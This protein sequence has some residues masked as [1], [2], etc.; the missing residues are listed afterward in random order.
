M[1][2]KQYSQAASQTSHLDGQLQAFKTAKGTY[3][4]NLS[5]ERVQLIDGNA[6]IA[7]AALF[8]NPDVPSQVLRKL[9]IN[10]YI[11]I[12]DFGVD[13]SSSALHGVKPYIN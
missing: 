4:V 13:D 7:I 5:Q 10:S 8:D 3:S 11:R 12:D 2:N 1:A 9:G 6:Y